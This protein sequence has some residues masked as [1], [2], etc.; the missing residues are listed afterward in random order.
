MFGAQDLVI[1]EKRFDQNFVV[2][3]RPE[4]LVRRIFKPDRRARVVAS[5][6]RVGQFS[7]PRIDLSLERLA[8]QVGGVVHE[9]H[10][11]ADL[12][13]TASEFVMYVLEID[14]TS[15]IQWIE[16]APTP[17]GECQICGMQMSARVVHCA[18]CRT[19]HHRE[20]WDW[21][22]VCSTFACLATRYLGHRA[23]APPEPVEAPARPVPQRPRPVRRPEPAP[24]SVRLRPQEQRLGIEQRRAQRRRRTAEQRRLR[25][26]ER[27]RR[28]EAAR[29]W[30]RNAARRQSRKA[31]RKR[32]RSERRKQRRRRGR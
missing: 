2:K 27:R 3:S 11:L 25:K 19:P 17:A 9:E 12:I 15:G 4:S 7:A 24:P 14:E 31:E 1:G 10:R 22:G 21:T 32:R 18:R 13:T 20:C 6:R 5:V 28:R 29:K 26:A 30:N 8:I 23:E 16:E